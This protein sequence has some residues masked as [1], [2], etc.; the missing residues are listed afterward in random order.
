MFRNE[1]EHDYGTARTHLDSG[2]IALAYLSQQDVERLAADRTPA[3][4]AATML[5]VGE[6]L[7]SGVVGLEER[8]IAYAIIDR[9]LPEAE[10]EIRAE[11]AKFLKNVSW[12]DHRLAT[13][14]A[15]HALQV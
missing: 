1:D 13:R 14:L 12:L 8:L 7:A 9:V 3:T 5:R 10:I 15:H 2:M 6:V 11:L 4:R